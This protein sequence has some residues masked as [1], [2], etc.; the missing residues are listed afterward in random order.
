MWWAPGW[1]VFGHYYMWPVV[2]AWA[3]WLFREPIW[4]AIAR[5]TKASGFGTAIE[6]AP[7]QSQGS[8]TLTAAATAVTAPTSSMRAPLQPASPGNPLG[9]NVIPTV[10]ASGLMWPSDSLP[11]DEKLHAAQDE[12]NS[13][14]VSA[15]FYRTFAVMFRSQYNALNALLAGDLRYSQLRPF[16]DDGKKR[17]L[18]ATFEDWLNFL[19]TS[20][21]V[22]R[23]EDPPGNPDILVNITPMGRTF[24]GFIAQQQLGPALLQY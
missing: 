10:T 21:F 24:L 7:T 12:R 6:M 13:W 19:V 15:M 20:A 5:M 17:G 3:V 22:T 11:P 18:T 14:L 9:P 2:V 23:R 16:Y 8:V 4:G 1:E